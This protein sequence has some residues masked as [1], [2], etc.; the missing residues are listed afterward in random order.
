MEG[1]EREMLAKSQRSMQT[2]I[3][4]EQG[5]Q[6]QIIATVQ[7]IRWKVYIK[8]ETDGYPRETERQCSNTEFVQHTK[9]KSTTR[10]VLVSTPTPT[11][12]QARKHK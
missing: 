1:S 9:I 4:R 12:D 3:N 2:P 11:S 8:T 6:N 7:Y 5:Q 10:T